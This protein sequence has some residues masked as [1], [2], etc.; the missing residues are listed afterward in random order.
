MNSIRNII[1]EKRYKLATN[2]NT[3]LSLDLENKTK[4]LNNEVFFEV[5]NAQN[6]FEVERNESNKYRFNGKLNIYTSN[7]LSTTA[8]SNDWDPLFK[9]N[10]PTTPNN[11]LCK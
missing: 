11:W 7:A 3:N 10:P 4:V 8:T 9:D 1:G 6:V 5:V 2:Q